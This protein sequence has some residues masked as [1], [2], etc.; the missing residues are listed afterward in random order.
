MQNGGTNFFECPTDPTLQS[1]TVAGGTFPAA[2]C[3]TT[4]CPCDHDSSGSFT[5]AFTC[6]AS[7]AG[8]RD[9]AADR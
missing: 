1:P 5:G 8:S 6:P 7:D 4:V 2:S 9:A 3:A